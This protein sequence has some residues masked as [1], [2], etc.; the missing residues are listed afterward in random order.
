MRR[1]EPKPARP[2]PLQRADGF[3]SGSFQR[4][5][6]RAPVTI[7][8]I[9]VPIRDGMLHYAGNPPVHVARVESIAAGDPAN[10]SELDLGAH[11]ATH[12]DAPVH[13]LADGAGA[14]TLPLDVLIGP[15]E[16]VDATAATKRARPRH[17]EARSG[18]RRPEASESSSRPGTPSS[19]TKTSSRA[20]SSAW[21]GRRPPSCSSAERSCSASTTSR[22]ATSMRTGRCSR[23]E[24]SASRDST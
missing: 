19:G 13:F 24:S 7:F 23:P 20:I 6:V 8:D 16:V 22:S 11:S 4:A 17:G 14:E 12:V 21:T 2:A 9:S 3:E 1:T 18:Y 5:M 10:V 15:A